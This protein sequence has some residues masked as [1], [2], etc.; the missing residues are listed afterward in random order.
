MK[1]AIENQVLVLNR[2]WQPIH[3]CSAR[4]AIGLLF[5]GHAHAVGMFGDERFSTHDFESWSNVED[6]PE[7]WPV[8]GSVSCQFCL[9]SIIV[10]VTFDRLPRKE[11]KFSRDNIFQRDKYV[12]QYC[13]KKFEPRDL[14][15]DHVFPKDKG[16]ETNWENVVTSCIKCNTRKGNKLPRECG[17]LP[18]T[19]PVAPRWRP[20]VGFKQVTDNQYQKS[21]SFFLEP[22]PSSVEL[23]S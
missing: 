6:R 16:G 1:S 2:L 12:C 8:V 20:L 18:I 7:G 5:L 17:M 21:W 15:L 4:R 9:P 22:N 10:L 13:K 11:I 14:N 19:P 23:S 3:M